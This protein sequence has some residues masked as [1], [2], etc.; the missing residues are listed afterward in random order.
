MG[1]PSRERAGLSLIVVLASACGGAGQAPRVDSGT[2]DD[3]PVVA[4]AG[5]DAETDAAIDAG[6]DAAV[7]LPVAPP[8]VVIDVLAG[9]RIGSE[10]STGW[11]MTGRAL[12]EFDWQQGPFAAVRLVVDLDTTCYPFEKWT[13]N[14]PPAGQNYPAD[15]D[16]FDRNFSAFIDDGPGASQA[17]AFEVMHAITPFGGPEQLEIDLTDLANARPG[18]HR[19]RV[20]LT[21]YSDTAGQSTGSNNGWTVSARV[22]L[23]PGAAPRRVLA[24]IPLYAG[25]VQMGD[26]PPLVS[27][28]APAGTVGGRLEY[29]TSGH[30][31]GAMDVDCIG[32]AEEFCNRRH[33]VL[34]DGAQAKDINPYRIDCAS[35]CTLQHHAPF[36]PFRTGLDYCAQNP[37]GLPSSVRASR[38]NWCPGSMTPPY[39]WPDIAALAVPGPHTFSF[40]VSRIGVGGF[41]M[42][43]AIYYAYGS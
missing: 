30:G 28:E 40:Q 34:I 39:S 1:I 31:Q 23:T 38:A 10:N 22:E 43:S 29:R 11:P 13:A 36:G 16:A 41:W 27:F 5:S 18:K 8:P 7:D 42:V 32:P 12:G 24:A 21:S 17:Q 20:E 6:I 4:E 35:L 2:G 37:L 9:A 33:S 25:Q 19:L 15:C 14:A 26:A 3:A